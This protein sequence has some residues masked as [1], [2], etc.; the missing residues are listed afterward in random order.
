[1]SLDTAVSRLLALG[2]A[3]HHPAGAVIGVR[4]ARGTEVAVGGW[5]RLPRDSDSGVP[6]TRGTR[7]DLASVTKVAATTVL[8]MLLVGQGRLQLETPAHEYLPV[9]RGDGKERVTIEQLLTHTAGLQPWWPL[10]FEATT[11]DAAIERAQ[12]LPL[13]AAPGTVWRYSDLGLILAG[14]V[15]ELVTGSGL[16]DAFRQLIAK[17][18]GLGAG[19]GPIPSDQAATSSDSDAYEYGMIA[20]NTPYPVPFTPAEFAGWRD[21]PLRGEANDGNA[22]HALAGVSGHAGLFAT[23]DELLTLGA[24]VREGGFVPRAVLERFAAPSPVEPTQ[25]VGFRRSE[26]R[27]GAGELTLLHHSGF[28]GTWFAVGLEQELV[29]AGGATRLYGNVGPLPNSPR[30]LPNG[31]ATGPEIAEVMRAAALAF[32]SPPTP[33]TSSEA[34]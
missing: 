17:P 33:A 34:R 15:A 4:T 13:A 5:A 29:V 24:A 32:L 25:A 9:F 6:L 14:R 12:T 31:L 20:A 7:L 19:Y 30:G 10:Y 11:R 16:A 22:A 23:V 1:M 18:L 27:T 2:D 26:H 3:D 8:T 28:T 21:R